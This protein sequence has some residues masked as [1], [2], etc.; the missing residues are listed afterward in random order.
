MSDLTH[1]LAV[2][3]LNY[4]LLY[5]FVSQEPNLSTVTVTKYKNGDRNQASII[6]Q[7]SKNGWSYA[8]NVTNVSTIYFLDPATGQPVYMNTA[9]GYA[10]KL[11]GNAVLTGADTA[12]VNYK[13]VGATT[14][15]SE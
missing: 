9:S 5:L 13:P 4:N 6:P 10:L 2:Q 14:S 1:Q 15:V 3:R 7:D 12:Q 8:G 11:N